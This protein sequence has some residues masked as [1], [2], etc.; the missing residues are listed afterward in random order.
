MK[1]TRAALLI[2]I[3]LGQLEAQTRR[4]ADRPLRRAVRGTRAAVATGTEPA[5]D[6]GMRLFYAGGNA[7]DAG[8]AALFASAVTEYS[9]FGFGGESPILIR[10]KTGKVVSIS[11]VGTMPKLGTPEFFR[12]RRL[13]PGE[14]TEVEPNGLKGFLPVAG[15]VPAL[16]PGMVDGALVALRDYGTK[17]FADVIGPAIEFADGSPLDEMRASY[18]AHAK[19]FADRWPATKAVLYPEGRMPVVGE[20][21]RQPDLARTM[22]AMVAVEKQALAQGKTRIA[23]IDAVR[24]YFYRGEI[25]R[26][27]DAFS[28]A[29]DGLLRYED[30]AAFRAAVEEPQSVNYRGLVVYKPGFWTQG[31]AMLEAL[32]ILE[33][34]DLKEMG[35]NTPNY[36]HTIVEALKLAYADRDTYYGDPKFAKI[37]PELLSREYATARRAQIGSRA[38]FDFR[39]G[40][41]QGKTGR[42]PSQSEMVRVKI[43]DD[44]LASDT[45]C[46]NAMDRDGIVFSA[47]PSGAWIPS[48][49]AGDTGIP[50]TQ[51]AQSFLL[52][53]GHPNEVAPG[54]R[55]RVTLSPTLVTR[56]G[57]PYLALS[58]P[59][60]DNQEQSLLQILLNIVEFGMNAEQAIEAPRAQTRHLVTSFDNHAMNPG[61]LILDDRIPVTTA[62]ELASRGHKVGQAS[63]WSSGAAPTVIRLASPVIEA[64]ADPYS[65]RVARAW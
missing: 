34:F 33:G 36:L 53:G 60:G 61:D 59:G 18:I 64:G 26:K 41:I 30:M 47:T 50:L 19:R 13:L 65:F 6:A 25:A 1:A 51:R 43:D 35:F 31:P 37:P 17:S 15:L 20:I 63:R 57:K 24:D 27:I 62:S 46:V 7:V 23:A 14:V 12:N 3:V 22:R 40:A 4:E 11:G 9:H 49:V 2:L 10:T 52:I 42:H 44:L 48:V 39:P 29:N 56:D 45:T 16:V 55:P 54:K 21:F 28:R 32:A 8:L 5:A 58:T 38:S